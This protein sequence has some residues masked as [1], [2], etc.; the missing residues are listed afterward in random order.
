MPLETTDARGGI[1]NV[2]R[3]LDEVP[4]G[5][6]CG[7]AAVRLRAGGGAVL[8]GVGGPAAT[9]SVRFLFRGATET[10]KETGAAAGNG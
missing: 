8:T 10:C 3:T 1:L 5:S 7:W 2:N 6:F 4:V 9:V